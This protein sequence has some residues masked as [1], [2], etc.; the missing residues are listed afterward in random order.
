MVVVI[1]AI[2]SVLS[3]VLMISIG[4]ILSHKGWFDEKTPKLFA[5]LMIDISIPALMVSNILSSFDK[6]KLVSSGIGLV[7]PFAAI[8]ISYAISMVISRVFRIKHERRGTFQL[9]CAFSNTI[10]VGLPVAISLFGQ[11]SSAFVFLYYFANTTL[12]WTIGIYGIRQDST[13]HREQLFTLSAFKKIFSPPFMGFL[14]GI[15]LIMLRVKLPIFIMNAAKYMGNL[16]IPMSMIYIGMIIYSIG[17]KEL[18]IDKDVIA[19]LAGRFIITPVIVFVLLQ[20]IPVPDLMRKVFIIVSAMPVMTQSAIV[21]Q[22]YGGDNRYATVMVTVT[23]AASL[24]F[25]P[26]YMF[27]LS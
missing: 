26:F 2:Q 5:R 1:N 21:T 7:I 25:I 10:F 15:I 19:L 23:T 24:I 14:T 17:F 12:F 4:Y 6:D 18:K 20:F 8:S 11:E 13:E 22:A 3:I 16:S 9:L 27:L